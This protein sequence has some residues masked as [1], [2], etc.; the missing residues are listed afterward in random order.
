MS[1]YKV[2][3]LPSGEVLDFNGEDSLLS[4]LKASGKKIKSSCGGCA[5]CSDCIIVVKEGEEN[6]TPQNFEE[7]RL[8]GN[9]FHITKER[10]SCQ[11]R[12]TGDVTIDISAHEKNTFTGKNESFKPQV[13]LKKKEEVEKIQKEREEKAPRGKG[14]TWFKHW[15]KEGTEASGPKVKKL[16]GNK[17]PK[18]FKFSES[19]EEN[20]S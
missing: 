2:T 15:E 12:L 7:L 6:L 1:D 3:L 11:T 5:T 20:N 18:P 4:Q 19:D 9:V 13:R 17:R 8:L 10:L 16:G 14:D